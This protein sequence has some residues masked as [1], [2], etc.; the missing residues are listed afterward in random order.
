MTKS[1]ATIV[2]Y[3]IQSISV[4]VPPPDIHPL[5]EAYPFA[6]PFIQLSLLRFK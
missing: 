4:V 3:V 5:L 1:L 6:L 2:S